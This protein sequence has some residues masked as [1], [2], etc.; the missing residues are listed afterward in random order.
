MVEKNYPILLA[1]VSQY[2]AEIGRCRDLE[3]V[4]LFHEANNP[5]DPLAIMVKT[6]RGETIGYLPM[7]NWLGN[8][9]HRNG[10]GATAQ[11]LAL[12]KWSGP[13]GVVLRA[14]TAKGPIA[15]ASYAVRSPKP[16]VAVTKP[17]TP[18]EHAQSIPAKRRSGSF[19]LWQRIG[20]LL[21]LL[22]R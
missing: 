8:A 5:H 2:Q 4:F 3:R 10:L 20:R 18:K 19:F 11:I 12:K 16:V 17:L 7:N 9:I 1:G 21:R 22:H 6:R 15:M 14:E 13:T